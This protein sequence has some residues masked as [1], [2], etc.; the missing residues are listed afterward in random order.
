MRREADDEVRSGA[1]EFQFQD[2]GLP[3]ICLLVR[4]T[5]AS[6]SDCRRSYCEESLR[7]FWGSDAGTACSGLAQAVGEWVA[8]SRALVLDAT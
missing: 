7:V 1:S 4:S 6:S 8:G 3:K 5:I 2:G